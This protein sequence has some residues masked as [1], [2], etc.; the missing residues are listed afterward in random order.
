MTNKISDNFMEAV[1]NYHNPHTLFE[2]AKTDWEKVVALQFI[3][4]DQKIQQCNNDIKWLQWLVKGVFAIGIIGL[5][6]D[7]IPRFFGA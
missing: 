1:A 4:Q 2:M 7:V 5:L 6:M 3:N